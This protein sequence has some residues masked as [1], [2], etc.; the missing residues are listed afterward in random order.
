MRFVFN[1]ELE[2][3]VDFFHE[4]IVA[5]TLLAG[6]DYQENF[7]DLTSLLGLEMFDTI[8]VYCGD[9][10]MELNGNYNHILGLTSDFNGDILNITLRLNNVV[11]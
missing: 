6:K 2:L 10:K 1:G 8:E 5:N 11:V 3:V 4:D 7:P 9:T